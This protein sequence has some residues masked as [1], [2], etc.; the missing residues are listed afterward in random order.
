MKTESEFKMKHTLGGVPAVPNQAL[1]RSFGEQKG[2]R[3]ISKV[4]NI[5]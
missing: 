4:F 3:C 1:D 2:N 5:Q